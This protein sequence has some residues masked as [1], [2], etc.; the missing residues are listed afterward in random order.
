M[1]G[2]V[3]PLDRLTE[4]LHGSKPEPFMPTATQY[5]L[6]R[7]PVQNWARIPVT[8]MLSTI[9]SEKQKP[10]ELKVKK[11]LSQRIYLLPVRTSLYC[12]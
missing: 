5:Y 9:S 6:A 10:I 8:E 7:L 1:I 3:P 2:N 11:K 4:T 12:R